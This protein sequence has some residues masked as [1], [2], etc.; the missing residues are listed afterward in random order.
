MKKY[1]GG[2]RDCGDLQGQ[3]PP[4]RGLRALFDYGAPL[5]MENPD[6]PSG[7]H[8]MV[9]AGDFVDLETGTGIVHMAPAFGEDDYRV[10][11]E[12]G[13]GF[14]CYVKPDGTFDERVTD[15]D[16]YDGSAIAGQFCKAA[17]K[18]IIRLLKERGQL[19]KHDQY[20]HAYPFCPRGRTIRSSSTRGR[21]GSSRRRS[22]RLPGEQPGNTWQLTHIRDGRFGNFLE[23]NVDWR[24]RASAIGA[25]AGV[26][27]R[28]DG[29]HGVSRPTPSC[30]RSRT[31]GA[32]KS[33]RRRKRR[34][35]SSAST[36]GAQA[37][38]RRGPL[39]EPEGPRWPDAPRD[40][41]DRRVVRRGLHA[42]RAVGYPHLPGSD[43]TN[44]RFPAD[45]ISEAIDQTRGWF[46]A[47]LAISTVVHGEEKGGWPHPFKN[48]ICLGHILGED[49]LKLSKRLKNYSEPGIL[50]EKFSADALR[51]SFIAKNPPTNSSRLS[52]RIVEESQRNCS[53]AGTT[54]TAFSLFTRTW[55]ASILGRAPT[56]CSASLYADPAKAPKGGDGGESAY[57]APAGARRA[58]PL[59]LSELDRVIVEV[60][61]A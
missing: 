2:C 51:W 53:S 1:F 18:A 45:F 11:K 27:P 8:W 3:R 7:K 30:W 29:P 32:R 48:C 20:R 41:S 38:H 60:R 21:V 49:G 23:N 37:L 59:I 56:P 40:G 12:K 55:T 14:L 24:F 36:Q 61:A 58:R 44:D 46:Y 6:Q 39:S 42:L 5:S 54:C 31:C 22:S 28:H 35:P 15:A 4:G 25:A 19:F 26:D 52:E 33:G 16:P 9:I 57:R 17:D 13:I 10:C 43:A 34:A 50:F 47:L